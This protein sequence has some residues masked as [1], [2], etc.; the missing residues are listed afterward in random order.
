MDFPSLL[1]DNIG[2]GLEGQIML[3]D[4]IG[5]WSWQLDVERAVLT[6]EDAATS[7]VRSS[8]VQFLGTESRSQGTWLW[9]WARPGREMP[10][11]S[12]E[13]ATRLRALGKEHRISQLASAEVHSSVTD[14]TSLSLL[15]TGVSGLPGWFRGPKPDGAVFV[16]LEDPSFVLPDTPDRARFRRTCQMLAVAG[17]L[18]GAAIRPA[19]EAY[20]RRRD[21]QLLPTSRHL[22]ATAPD[23]HRV[24]ADF[25]EQGRVVQLGITTSLPPN[26]KPTS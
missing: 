22:T 15:A 11:H 25:D 2:V 1:L 4:Q 6:L 8:T 16:L 18:P 14:G 19:L 20:L 5:G 23:G 26:D 3:A 21:F 7:R 10:A 24:T 9:S 13:V 12:L 17:R